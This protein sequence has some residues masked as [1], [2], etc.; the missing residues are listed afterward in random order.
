[1]AIIL[2]WMVVE[3]TLVTGYFFT[4]HFLLLFHVCLNR[5]A[6]NSVDDDKRL[7]ITINKTIILLY[8]VLPNSP[9]TCYM[10]IFCIGFLR[11]LPTNTAR[12]FRQ[13]N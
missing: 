7:Q 2:Q 1:M 6:R 10:F 3:G 4:F 12:H 5:K 11:C 9:T 8:I 13:F